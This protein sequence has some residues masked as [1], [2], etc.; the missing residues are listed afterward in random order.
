MTVPGPSTFED[1]KPYVKAGTWR[2]FL[3]W[4]VDFVVFVFGV[5]AGVVVLSVVDLKAQLDNGVIAL[6]LV[7]IMFLV[8]LLYGL[9]Y[10]NGRALGAVLTGTRLVRVADG[11]RIGGKGPWAMLVRTVLL[12]LLLVVVI[13]G[14]LTGGGSAPGGSQ[15][16]ISVDDRR[17]R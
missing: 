4:L 8:P 7:A 15:V 16:R 12:P 13:V 3:A 1:G 10:R 11:G 9:C 14:A 2:L 17:G 5:L 6:G